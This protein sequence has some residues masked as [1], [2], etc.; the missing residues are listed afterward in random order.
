MK[1]KGR[2][3]GGRGEPA[4]LAAR[5]SPQQ[6]H[7]R[8]VVGSLPGAALHACEG[9]VQVMTVSS[10]WNRGGSAGPQGRLPSGQPH[11]CVPV[12]STSNAYLRLRPFPETRTKASPW[13]PGGTPALPPLG[14]VYRQIQ[15]RV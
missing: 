4:G 11:L 5:L 7:E 13:E 14:C 1:F 10:A 6:V 12:R 8:Q 9:N 2:W 3:D 15:M